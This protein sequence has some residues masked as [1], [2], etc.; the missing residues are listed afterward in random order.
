MTSSSFPLRMSKKEKSFLK[1]I[2]K[3]NSVS[4]NDYIRY[5]IFVNNQD[6]SE[7][8]II[9]ETPS[10]QKHQYLTAR[11]LQDIYLLILQMFAENKS[12][13]EALE[14]K[15]TCREH[16]EQN[17]AKFGYFKIDNLKIDNFNNN[18]RKNEQTAPED[19][20]E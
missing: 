4:M 7:E 10:K 8:E 5:R 13:E 12:E 14:F 17:I 18:H 9:Y 2:A 16:A 19:F 3:D 1:R 15:K 6:F 11:I 20:I